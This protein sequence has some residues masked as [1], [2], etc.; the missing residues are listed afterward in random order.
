MSNNVKIYRRG[1]GLIDPPSQPEDMD[2][3]GGSDGESEYEK[4]W[5]VKGA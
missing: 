5:K 2:I 4:R 1:V 3:Q